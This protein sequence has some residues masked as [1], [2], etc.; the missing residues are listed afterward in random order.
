MLEYLEGRTLADRLAEG[1]LPTAE[2]LRHAIAICSALD[3]AHR[4]GIVHRDLKPANVMLTSAGAKL[5]DFGLAKSAGPPAASV[6][7]SMTPNAAAN[8]TA[9]GTIL[10]TIQYMAPEQID[11]RTADARTD[12]FAFGTL[13]FEMLTGRTAFVG[14]TRGRYS[15]RSSGTTPRRCRSFEPRFRRR[16][17]ASSARAWQKS[18]TTGIRAPAIS[19]ASSRGWPPDLMTTPPR[20]CRPYD[21]A[22]SRGW[23]PRW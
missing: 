17:I 10:G 2:P 21:R 11:G 14:N 16:S 9:E 20:R 5:L 18:R 23:L 13:L 8:L 3:T 19:S 7:V 1:A 12:I 4:S 15:G 6:T 22:A